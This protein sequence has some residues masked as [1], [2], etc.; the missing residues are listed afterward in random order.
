MTFKDIELYLSHTSNH[1]P[2]S[3]AAPVCYVTVA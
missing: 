3:A 2:L 1:F